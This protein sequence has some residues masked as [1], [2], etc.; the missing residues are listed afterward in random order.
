[1]EDLPFV[2]VKKMK[3]ICF[4]GNSYDK[5]GFL[6]IGQFIKCIEDDD[7]IPNNEDKKLLAIHQLTDIAKKFVQ[8]HLNQNWKSLKKI[9]FNKFKSKLTLKEKINVRRYLVQD[10][11]ESCKQFHAR[12]VKWQFLLCDDE[13]DSVFERDILINFVSGLKEDIYKQLVFENSISD[14]NS[15]LK[16]AIQIEQDLLE[17]DI[18][19]NVNIEDIKPEVNIKAEEFSDN[20]IA[21]DNNH[22][23]DLND[24]IKDEGYDDNVKAPRPKRKSTRPLSYL[25][26][27]ID[28]PNDNN[29]HDDNINDNNP[30]DDYFDDNDDNGSTTDYENDS[31]SDFEPT[32]EDLKSIKNQNSGIMYVPVSCSL[33]PK[34]FTSELKL[35]KHLIMVHKQN[36]KVS[37]DSF[38]KC[39]FCDKVLIK[40]PNFKNSLTALKTHL[41]RKH[42]EEIGSIP[43]FQ[44][45]FCD[46]CPIETRFDFNHPMQYGEESLAIHKVA[47]VNVYFIILTFLCTNEGLLFS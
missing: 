44:P 30:N 14:L 29:P 28:N 12:C 16:L 35:Q 4:S 11:N 3:N 27:F 26:E 24:D 21:A 46:F 23:E 8:P 15:C 18:F 20:E 39:K 41:Y 17:P 2:Y 22:F 1:M 31:G 6:S 32:E 25:E 10:E 38:S 45:L 40:N 33:C 37:E 36:D 13:F 9:L 7:A 43:E 42:P 5:D 47:V 34:E 19:K